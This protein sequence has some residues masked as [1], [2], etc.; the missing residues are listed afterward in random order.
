MASILS[1]KFISFCST[2]TD[3]QHEPVIEYTISFAANFRYLYKVGKCQTNK[4]RIKHLIYEGITFFYIIRTIL[5]LETL[6]NSPSTFESYKNH[7]YF[8]YFTLDSLFGRDIF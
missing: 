1:Q 8:I 2:N 3:I 5:G 7:D 6:L 4:Y